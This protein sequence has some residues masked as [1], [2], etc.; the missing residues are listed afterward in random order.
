MLGKLVKEWSLGVSGALN[1][2]ELFVL[3]IALAL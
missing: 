2:R 1:D 3:W